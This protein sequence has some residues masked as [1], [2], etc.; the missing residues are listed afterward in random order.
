VP[1]YLNNVLTDDSYPNVQASGATDPTA[2]ILPPDVYTEQIVFDVGNNPVYMQ[3]WHYASQGVDATLEEREQLVTAGL[4]YVLTNVAGARW[5]SASPG[6]PAVII[7][8]RFSVADQRLSPGLAFTGTISHPI[9]NLTPPPVNPL[10]QIQHNGAVVGTEQAL[11]FEDSAAAL[12]A[13]FTVTDNSVS[14]RVQVSAVV[15]PSAVVTPVKIFDS[16]LGAP[17]ASFTV[18]PIATLIAA[19]GGST[20]NL[21]GLE[22]H[23]LA[24]CSS[25]VNEA[26]V[27][28]TLNGDAGANYDTELWYINAATVSSVANTAGAT[29]HTAGV[30]P[31]TSAPAGSAGA[32]MF[33]IPN[34]DGTAFWKQVTGTFSDHTN[35]VTTGFHAGMSGGTWKNTAAVTGVGLS[36]NT[37]N[38]VA[39]SRLVVYAF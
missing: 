26:Q 33:V 16:I 35:S 7:A 30:I 39:G 20:A 11:D 23:L 24:A 15:N 32:C 25:A 17:A 9:G 13:V 27:L 22:L 10:V 12:G 1:D 28:M 5:R 3:V 37:G 36:L 19:A 34:F 21:H 18:S 31:G 4:G 29:S 2:A 6:Q 8:K 38:L 14:G